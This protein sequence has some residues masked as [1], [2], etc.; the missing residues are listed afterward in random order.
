MAKHRKPEEIVAK[1][2]QADVL[3]SQNQSLSDTNYRVGGLHLD[4]RT[5]LLNAAR[6]PRDRHETVDALTSNPAHQIGAESLPHGL[7]YL[8]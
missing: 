4:N 1:L 3:S 8:R 6:Q 5:E 7:T 2:R